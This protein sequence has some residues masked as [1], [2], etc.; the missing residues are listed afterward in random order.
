MRR[1]YGLVIEMPGRYPESWVEELRE[2]ADLVQIISS[3]VPLKKK[4]RNYWGLCPFHGEKTASFSVNPEGRFYYCFGCK[5]GGSVI[6][7]IMEMEHLTYGEALK[8]LADLVHLP[9]PQP[10]DDPDYQKRQ[11]QNERLLNANREA[12]RFFHQTLFTDAGKASL[13]YLRGRGLNDHVIRRFGLGAAPDSWDSLMKHLTSMGFTA[14]ELELA[15]LTVVKEAENATA[16]SPARPRRQYDMFRN[17]AMFPIIDAHGNVRGFGGRILGKGQ[18]KYLNT[19]DTPIYNKRL[20]VYAANLLHKERHLDHVVLVEGYMDVIALSQYG[21]KGVVA[22]L[23]TSLTDEQARLIKRYVPKVYLAYDGD[24]AGQ[25]AI[26]RGLEIFRNAGMDVRVLDFPD[27]L[28]P[29][30]FIRRDGLEGFENLPVLSPETYRL[31]RLKE[32]YDLSTKEGRTEYAKAAG[33]ILK[34]LEPVELENH[35]QDLVLQ[36][37][38]SRDVLLAQ[39]GQSRPDPASSASAPIRT[40]SVPRKVPVHTLVNEHVRGEELLISLFATGKL[41]PDELMEEE[42]FTD[43][44]LKDVFIDLKS[45]RSPAAII[46]KQK[47][48]EDVA[49]ASRLMT[50]PPAEDTNELLQLAK[51]GMHTMR[52]A[53]IDA[54][55]AEI[56][57]SMSAL[58]PDGQLRAMTR[59]ME[60]QKMRSRI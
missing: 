39:I 18:P 50:P 56:T 57:K 5:A 54:E 10:V 51:Q 4:G 29:D 15:G 23:G 59:L 12:A 38:F 41:P 14:Q 52:A 26:L 24:S 11:S 20:G 49:R 13:D 1:N 32:Q 34:G 30:E 53:R 21:V 25:H 36:T 3:Y 55:I 46:E 27:G 28:D 9:V 47:T 33:S 42:D 16:D 7:F 37:G 35:L 44:F 48:P 19:S 31:R 58:P 40:P 2:R 60:L 45:G 8:Y 6:N 17:R 22:T 43:P